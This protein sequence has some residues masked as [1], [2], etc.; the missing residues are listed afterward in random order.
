IGRTVSLP[1][2]FR[3]TIGM[4]VTGSIINPRIFISTSIAL[5]LSLRSETALGHSCGSD[6]IAPEQRARRVIRPRPLLNHHAQQTVGETP[7][8]DHVNIA[9]HGRH[10]TLRSGKVQ[11]N[12]LRGSTN[13]LPTSL[14]RTFN[15]YFINSPYSLFIIDSLDFPLPFLQDLEPLGFLTVIDAINHVQRRRVG[16]RRILESKDA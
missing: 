14:I 9:A 11:G 1:T 12:V 2:S 7:G 4:L 13:K 3:T 16:T 10:G 8:N 5:L 6:S 15:H